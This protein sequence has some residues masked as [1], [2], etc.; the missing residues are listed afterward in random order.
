MWLYCGRTTGRNKLAVT[1]NLQQGKSLQHY[2]CS[3]G[4][5]QLLLPSIATSCILAAAERQGQQGIG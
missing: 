1:L 3:C 5:T 4:D 2:S